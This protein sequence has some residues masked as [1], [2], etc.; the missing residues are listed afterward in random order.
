MTKEGI[1][2]STA[3]FANKAAEPTLNVIVLIVLFRTV[4]FYLQLNQ[5]F[6][7]YPF[8]YLY[9]FTDPVAWVDKILSCWCSINKSQGN[10]W[11]VSN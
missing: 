7:K 11:I 6:L 1:K 10:K 8:L 2:T 3:I 9:L 5:W 4:L